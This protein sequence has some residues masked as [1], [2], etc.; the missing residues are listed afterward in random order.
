MLVNNAGVGAFCDVERTSSEQWR[1]ALVCNLDSVFLGTQLAIERMKQ[2]SGSIINVASLEHTF[3]GRS[4]AFAR[5]A[6]HL[7]CGMGVVISLSNWLS[8]PS[9]NTGVLVSAS[10]T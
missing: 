3:S 5:S 4:P 7:R 1:H 10:R 2:R 9:I 6:R 8:R